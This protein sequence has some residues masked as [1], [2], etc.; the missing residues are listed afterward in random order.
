[1]KF[2]SEFSSPTGSDLNSKI[3][4]AEDNVPLVEFYRDGAL[5]G[6][7]KFPNVTLQYAEDA[8]ENFVMEIGQFDF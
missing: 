1:M 8:A 2:L 6:T 4:L 7:R 5:V 3:Y